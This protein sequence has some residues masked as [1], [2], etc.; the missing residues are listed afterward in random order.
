MRKQALSDRQELS[1]DQYSN[2]VNRPT[3]SLGYFMFTLACR[4]IA[5]SQLSSAFIPRMLVV[6]CYMILEYPLSVQ[7]SCK[8]QASTEQVLG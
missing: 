8:H 3:A 1:R 6:K 5:I 2:E 4:N 7:T